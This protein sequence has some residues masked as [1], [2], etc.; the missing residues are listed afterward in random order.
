MKQQYSVTNAN[1]FIQCERVILVD[2]LWTDT[3]ATANKA[4]SG[5][6]CFADS[7]VVAQSSVL[8]M[9]FRA[10]KPRHRIPQNVGGNKQYVKVIMTSS[11][12]D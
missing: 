4:F 6:P 11:Q 12:T 2:L 3:R 1:C 8:R 9:K 10:N 7:F 5:I